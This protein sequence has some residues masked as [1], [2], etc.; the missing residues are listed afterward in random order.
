MVPETTYI[1]CMITS[2]ICAVLLLR[3]YLTTKARMLL[4]SSLCFMSLII[5]NFMLF[6]DK[7]VYPDVDFPLLVLARGWVA[8]IGLLLLI[9]GLIWDAE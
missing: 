7:V 9:F 5:N 1:L 2:I 4:W 8:L 3:A 6:I